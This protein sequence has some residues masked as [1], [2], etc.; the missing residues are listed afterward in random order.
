MQAFLA[1]EMSQR[2]EIYEISNAMIIHIRDSCCIE[3]ISFAAWAFGIPSG[4]PYRQS[5][6]QDRDG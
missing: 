2:T 6:V 4:G 3:E 5:E 1:E